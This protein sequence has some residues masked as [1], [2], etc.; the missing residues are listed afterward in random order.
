[1]ENRVRIDVC[2]S[3]PLLLKKRA[4]IEPENAHTY[5]NYAE[6]VLNTFKHS[7]CLKR[8]DNKML[9]HFTIEKV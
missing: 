4:Y 1:M 9:T 5:Y 6:L 2:V 3:P 7:N 8:K